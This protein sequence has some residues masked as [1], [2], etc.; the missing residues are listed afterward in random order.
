MVSVSTAR[1][2]G[3][4]ARLLTG[5]MATI[6][7]SPTAREMDRMKAAVM[8]TTPRHD[9]LIVVCIRTRRGEALPRRP[10]GTAAGR[11]GERRDERQNHEPI[12]MRD[13]RI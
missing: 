7:V 13:E 12:T 11:L 5:A 2:T 3:C 9:N 8:R 4:E 10:V 6:M 1:R